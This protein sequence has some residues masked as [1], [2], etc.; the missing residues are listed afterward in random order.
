MNQIPFQPDSS[1]FGAVNFAENAEP[2]CPCVLI[3]DVSGSMQGQ[4]ISQL[5]AGLQI[6]K[7][8]LAADSL[9]AK[10]V[11]VAIVTFGGAV[12]VVGDF[13]TA[14]Q[15]KPPVL[16]ASGDTPMGAA[17]VR[18]LE[19]ISERKR[20]YRDNGI[21][22]YRPWVFMITDGGPTDA[23]KSA[24]EQV[25]QGEAAKSFAFFAVGVGEANF[26]VLR[27]ITVREP[28]KLDGLRFRDLFQWLSNSQ[29]SV[30]RSQP[31]DEV[32]LQNPAGPGGWT[33]I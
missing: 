26:E 13:A 33:T 7:D 12:Q 11:E 17:I 23:W 1:P 27:Q 30:S 10:R 31:G 6:Y 22:F 9:A 25:R 5:N 14:D 29:Q 20:V 24:A 2:R 19:M 16:H 28:L 21:M 32:P 8:E 15:F 3:L 18:S 4:P